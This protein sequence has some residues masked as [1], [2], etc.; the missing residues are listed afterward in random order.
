MHAGKQ[1]QKRLYLVKI[2]TK[3]GGHNLHMHDREVVTTIAWPYKLE[4]EEKWCIG[5][6]KWE[7]GE[8]HMEWRRR[9]A[10]DDAKSASIG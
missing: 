9:R 1:K 10:G 7:N 4:V 8:M 6:K 3:G 2:L 5:Q